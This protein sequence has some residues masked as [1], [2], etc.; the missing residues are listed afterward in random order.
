MQ[1]KRPRPGAAVLG[2]TLVLSTVLA[3]GDDPNPVT[4]GEPDEDLEAVMTTAIQDEY[5]AEAVYLKFLEDHGDVLPFFNIVVAEV[6]HSTSIGGLFE[7][8][9]WAVPPSEW[10]SGNV[11]A[12]ATLAEACAAGVEAEQGNIALYDEL[13]AQ[14]LPFD[15]LRV[16]ENVRAASLNNH[17]P[18]F[19]QCR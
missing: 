17:L 13:L 1:R 14:E 15:V 7:S 8:R 10:S 4:P 18:A 6:R 11:P 3:C 2:L 9:G 16:F 12:F 5:H 19:E